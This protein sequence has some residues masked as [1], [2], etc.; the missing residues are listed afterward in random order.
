M[1]CRVRN[2][3]VATC[4]V[5]LL[6]TGLLTVCVV[7][8]LLR[9]AVGGGIVNCLCCVLVVV[10]EI[11]GLKRIRV[12]VDSVVSVL[13]CDLRHKAG[14]IVNFRQ[15]RISAGDHRA[16]NRR[17]RSYSKTD[18]DHELS[19]PN[20]FVRCKCNG[21]KFSFASGLCS[22]SLKLKTSAEIHEET[23]AQN[24]LPLLV[25]DVR[26]V[27]VGK[28]DSWI[29]LLTITTSMSRSRL[30]HTTTRLTD[31]IIDVR[32]ASNRHVCQERRL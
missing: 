27:S 18:F 32:S 19:Y 13:R 11:R 21:N 7:S 15:V 4:L 10:E 29:G 2:S 5:L 14:D 30:K 22:D 3:L 25:T 24:I 12:A 8:L 16:R 23:I 1:Y 6:V 20:E 26:K 31:S 28:A 9:V 17:A